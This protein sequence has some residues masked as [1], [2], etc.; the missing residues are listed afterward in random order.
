MKKTDRCIV[1]GCTN[2]RFTR[3]VCQSCLRVARNKI[4]C[5]DIT[6]QQLIDDGLLLP[7][8]KKGRKSENALAKVLEKRA[9]GGRR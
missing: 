6:E 4:E 9:K 8:Q 5:G 1:P 7:L 3:G 2:T